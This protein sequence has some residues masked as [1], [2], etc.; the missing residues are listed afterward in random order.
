MATA[1]PTCSNPDCKVADDGK[2]VETYPLDECPHYGRPAVADIEPI[3]EQPEDLPPAVDVEAPVIALPLGEALGRAEASALQRRRASRA[4]GVVGPHF[5]GK[6]SLMASVYEILQENVV[7]GYSFAGS[8][9][10]IGFEMICH[11]ARAA[12]K[13]PE[14][15]TERTTVGADA[16]FFHLDLGIG[17]PATVTSLFIGDR[18]GEDYLTTVDELSNAEGFFE[19]KR[20]DVVT[21]LVNG[22]HLADSK[23][24]HEVKA[25]TPQLV[26]AL[27][28]AG[29]ISARQRVALV[30]TKKDA[31]AAS[32]HAERVVSDFDA[33]VA[34]VVR[35]H[36]NLVT[37]VASFVVA[38]SPRIAN[39][40]NRGEGVSDLVAYWMQPVAAE[41]PP[42]AQALQ[43]TRMIDR[44]PGNTERDA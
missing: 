7:A 4:I 18:S 40:V 21:I 12:S 23:L 3:D 1:A 37:G 32:A 29:S 5:A 9:T 44:V 35:R 41:T 17:E 25:S 13:R 22:E 16:T 15:H 39:A 10:L 24:R 26:D 31:V 38:A 19:L 2:C 34:A 33:M 8:S 14:P 6:T 20:A 27:V 36:G 30:L 11:D 42:P 28:E 43:M